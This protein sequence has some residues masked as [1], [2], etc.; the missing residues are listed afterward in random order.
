MSGDRPTVLGAPPHAK[1]MAC[2]T[3]L[4]PVPFGPSTTLRRGPGNTSHSSNVKKFFIDTRI[5][6]PTVNLPLLTNAGTSHSLFR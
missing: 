3:E 5:T 2:V 4:F 1:Q 6:L